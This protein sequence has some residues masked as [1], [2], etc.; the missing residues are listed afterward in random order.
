MVSARAAEAAPTLSAA[1]VAVAA[2][3]F[4]TDRNMASGNGEILVTEDVAI[5]LRRIT[6]RC[7]EWIARSAFELARSR[8]RHVTI[9]HKANVLKVSDGM[10]LDTCRSVAQA[11]PDVTT[12]DILIDAKMAHVVRTPARFDVVVTTNMYGDILSD[13]TAE[14]SGN[15]GMGG[16]LNAGSDHAMA[17]ASHG[18][19][20]DIAGRDIANPISLILSTAQLLEWFGKRK[21]DARY[22]EAGIRISSAVEASVRTGKATRDI[23]GNLGTRAVGQAIAGQI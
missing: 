5:A 7:C 17:Q 22:V 10:F 4:Y 16:S 12:D 1:S 14:F 8:N 2:E 21:S 3:G 13:L 6:K 23:G 11:Y 19:A 20:P 9:V 18:S 15:L